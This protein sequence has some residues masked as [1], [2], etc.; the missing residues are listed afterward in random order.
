MFTLPKIEGAPKRC[1]RSNPTAK[2]GV[3]S[4]RS[5]LATLSKV[6]YPFLF[7]KMTLLAEIQN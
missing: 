4:P 7:I 6:T 3:L 5:H 1:V 2:N